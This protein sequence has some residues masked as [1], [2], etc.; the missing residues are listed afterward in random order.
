V[1]NSDKKTD[2]TEKDMTTSKNKLLTRMIA[3]FREVT[4]GQWPLG[5]KKKADVRNGRKSPCR[6]PATN[7]GCRAEYRKGG[8][9]PVEGETV[10]SEKIKEKKTKSSETPLMYGFVAPNPYLEKG[11]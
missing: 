6:N 5:A 11:G 9:V 10:L 3:K 1:I 8:L 4:H 2:P 7:R